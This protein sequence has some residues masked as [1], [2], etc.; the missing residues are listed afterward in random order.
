M[1]FYFFKKGDLA[2]VTLSNELIALGANVNAQV[3]YQNN[4]KN[5]TISN[6]FFFKKM[7]NRMLAVSLH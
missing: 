7:K 1:F 5:E 3:Y 2:A 6:L 4:L